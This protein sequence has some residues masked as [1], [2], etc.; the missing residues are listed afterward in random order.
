VDADVPQRVPRP[1]DTWGAE[2]EALYERY[3]REGKG[4]KHHQGAGA[5]VRAILE[6]QIETGTPYM[7]FKDACN[8]KSNQQ[9]LGTIKSSNLCTEI[10][11]YTS[12]DEVAVCNLA[13]IALPKFVEKGKFD[14]DRS[15]HVVRAWRRAT[16]TG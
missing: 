12:P 16:S 14:H 11:E 6:S 2:F 1:G 15:S 5:L 8:A 9:N 13:S 3:E 4:R 10:I 7:L